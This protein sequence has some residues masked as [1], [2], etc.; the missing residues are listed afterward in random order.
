MEELQAKQEHAQGSNKQGGVVVPHIVPDAMMIGQEL[1]QDGG[2]KAGYAGQSQCNRGKPVKYAL[3]RQV[4]GNQVDP[5]A[6]SAK[7]H[8][9]L[10][11]YRLVPPPTA[12]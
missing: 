4:S 9:R 10:R 8:V 3:L 11:C 1:D 2:Y 6:S 7:A 5:I 12:I